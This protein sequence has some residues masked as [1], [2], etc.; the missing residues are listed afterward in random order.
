MA[1]A[2][3][4]SGLLIDPHTAV[5]L[6]GAEVREAEAGP[7]TV[8]LSTAH[9]A[10]FPDAVRVATGRVPSP[11]EAVIARAGLAERIDR[12]PADEAALEDYLRAFA[13]RAG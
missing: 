5:A 9:P 11:P 13:S 2:L 1:S 8:V 6:A 4:R 10:K 12:L 7:C 3:Q